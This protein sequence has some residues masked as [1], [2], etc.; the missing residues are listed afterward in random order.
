[1]EAMS[2]DDSF[3]EPEADINALY[4]AQ[5]CGHLSQVQAHLAGT[6]SDNLRLPSSYIH[7]TG[8]WTAEEKDNFFHALSVHSRFRPDLIAACIKTKTILDVCTY[9]DVLDNALCRNQS[10]QP[11]RSELECAMEVSN[12]WVQWEEANADGLINVEPKWEEVAEEQQHREEISAEGASVETIMVAGNA[13]ADPLTRERDRRRYWKQES[14]LKRLEF[15]HLRVME[16]LLRQANSGIANAGADKLQPEDQQCQDS[17][18]VLSPLPPTVPVCDSMIDP[19]LLR[20]SQSVLTQ[21]P[22]HLVADTFETRCTDQSFLP[23]EPSSSFQARNVSSPTPPASP[24]VSFSSLKADIARGTDPSD[25]TPSS[26]RR[27]HKRLYMRRKRAEQKGEEA[28]SDVAK[29]RPGRKAKERR[30]PKPRPKTYN[31]KNKTASRKG[32]ASGVVMEVGAL[33]SHTMRN[34]SRAQEYTADVSS[35]D[36]EESENS[37]DDD[38][39]HQQ[40]HNVGGLTRPYRIKKDF[41]ENG[42]DG[43]TLIDGNLGLF[44]LSFLGRLMKYAHVLFS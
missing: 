30:P 20:L 39:D 34:E 3:P 8:Y 44:H 26:R 19:V 33:L 35:Q 21:V 22:S 28:I 40:H 2:E 10:L 16:G 38:D 37:D 18:S 4:V 29:L 13:G 25:L 23:S 1:V 7:P 6:D 41:A 42:I 12:S 24:N 15:H 36:H 27:F 32:D 5:F 31:T 17:I 11:L 9:I 43:Q 14:V